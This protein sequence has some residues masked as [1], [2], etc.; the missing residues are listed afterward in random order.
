MERAVESRPERREVMS[1]AT[2]RIEH[3][4]LAGRDDITLE[5]KMKVDSAMLAASIDAVATQ[6][7]QAMVSYQQCPRGGRVRQDLLV[8][9]DQLHE[10]LGHLL[11]C[12]TRKHKE[13]R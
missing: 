11:I 13:E 1:S 7:S 5:E 9:V 8:S 4:S 2:G 6:I 10:R 12:L 3:P